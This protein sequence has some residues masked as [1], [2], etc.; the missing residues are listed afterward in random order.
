MSRLTECA[1]NLIGLEN[2]HVNARVDQVLENQEGTITLKTS[3]R[4]ERVGTFDKVVITIPPAAL[5]KVRVRPTWPFMKE[6]ALRS[7]H[8]EPLYKIGLHFRTRF[9]ENLPKP[10]LG[11]QSATDLQFRW[12]VYPSNDLGS[13]GSG[14]LL[15]YCWMN[16]AYRM[17]STPQFERF[18]LVLHDPQ[19]FYAS[20]L[21]SG[22]RDGRRHVSSRT[23]QPLLRYLP[24]ARGQY[25]LC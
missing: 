20:V 14:V 16:D 13:P 2:I 17:A 5:Q 25:I 10:C 8:Y 11:G 18:Q 7:I 6:Q 19:R 23:V 3:G 12:I 15:L 21:E 9:W 4:V 24:A 1:S 22:V